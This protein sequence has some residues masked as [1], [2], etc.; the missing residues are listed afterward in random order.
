[1]QRIE[2]SES[3]SRERAGAF[4]GFTTDR[5]TDRCRLQPEKSRQPPVFTRI[6]FVLEIMRG[7]THEMD[8]AA[9][10]GIQQGS[11]GFGLAPHSFLRRVIERSLE[12][13]DVEVHNLAHPAIVP[14]QRR[15]QSEMAF[16]VD[17]RRR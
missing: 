14:F 17:S 9:L 13:A 2:R 4:G 1:M 15:R 5:R 3:K 6:T 16:Q 12:A 10:G 7:G 11:H 8:P